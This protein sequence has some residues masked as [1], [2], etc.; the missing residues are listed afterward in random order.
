VYKIKLLYDA[1]G[2]AHWKRC[3]TL[4]KYAPPDF[5]VDIGQGVGRFS[6]H[7][8]DLI[9]QLCCCYASQLRQH[10]DRMR[11]D[12]ALVSAINVGWSPSNRLW[13][14]HNLKESDHVIINNRA[15]WDESGHRDRTTWISNGVDL[16]TWRIETPVEQ[17]RPTVLF[18]GSR[19][20]TEENRDTKGYRSILKPLQRRLE[21]A[22]F[23][24]DFRRVNSFGCRKMRD[25]KPVLREPDYMTDDELREL[26]NTA[27]VYVVASET[28]GTPNPAL[29]AAGCGATVCATRVGN[30]PEL[31]VPG[32]NGELVERTQ[33]AV[34]DGIVRC[35]A[36]YQGYATA[37]QETLAGWSWEGRAARYYDLFRALLAGR[38]SA[39]STE[40]QNSQTR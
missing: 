16:D 8:Y 37:M 10:L 40:P 17:R 24:V 33:D 23:A 13:L 7:R 28:E 11:H 35:Q 22:G 9:L 21:A 36:N 19:F 2:W 5:D 1:P 6:S 26:Y 25:G 14:R 27:T 38:T 12:T 18:V 31:I 20:H 3:R 39:A 32:V 4:R 15:F 30:M 34:F 29:E